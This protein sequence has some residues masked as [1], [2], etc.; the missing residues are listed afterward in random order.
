MDKVKIIALKESIL[1]DNDQ[2]A[3][4]LREDLHSHGTCLLNLM[5]SPGSGKTTTLLALN[6]AFAGRLRWGVMEADID[7]A[8]DANTMLEAG[9]PTVQ[10]HT[11]GMCHLDA[12]MTRQGIAALGMEDAELIVLENIGNLVCPAEFDTGAAINMTILSVPEGDDKPAKYPLMYETSDIL[13]IN[14]IDTLPIFDFDKAR[15]ERDARIRNP[16]IEIFYISAKT[17]EG[18][19]DLADA[20]V[21][22]VKEWNAK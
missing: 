18:V 4:T 20:L 11:G 9:V 12:D 15:V 17:G 6:K 2:D 19:Q 7:S 14:K 13:V 21:R 3:Q 1:E 5:S 10:L 8:V 16:K 22:K